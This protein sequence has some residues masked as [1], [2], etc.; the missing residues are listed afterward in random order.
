MSN[1]IPNKTD[2]LATSEIKHTSDNELVKYESL[3]NNSTVDEA[4]IRSPFAGDSKNS[5]SN[6]IKKD[7]ATTYLDAHNDIEYQ[8]N[9]MKNKE[10]SFLEMSTNNEPF[11]GFSCIAIENVPAYINKTN[12]SDDNIDN[13][14]FSNCSIQCSKS[15]LRSTDKDSKGEYSIKGIIEIRDDSN[16]NNSH[17]KRSRFL[18]SSQSH[19]TNS[20][21]E[22]LYDTCCSLNTSSNN[23]V[24]NEN[25]SVVELEK[26]NISCLMPVCSTSI[27]ENYSKEEIEELEEI[28]DKEDYIQ[29]EIISQNSSLK[30]IE[31][32]NL[33]NSNS[34]GK[35]ISF[36]T[37]RRR[38]DNTN[39]NVSIVSDDSVYSFNEKVCD[40]TV[41][42]FTHSNDLI[43]SEKSN[44]LDDVLFEAKHVNDIEQNNIDIPDTETINVEVETEI[45]ENPQIS[46]DVRNT[47]NYRESISKPIVLQPGKKWERSL[48]IYKRMTLI[49]D[50]FDT[51]MIS[52][53]PSSTRKMRQPN[54]VI[55][56]MEMQRGI[57]FCIVIFV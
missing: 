57:L 31:S 15:F 55:N 49:N 12:I 26:S 37:I 45:V 46:N 20:V 28:S 44:N 22:S 54:S 53:E 17:K 52:E 29:D 8:N 13:S 35:Y 16:D 5:S 10:A 48:S 18:T 39:N 30:S 4:P 36:V 42:S 43:N 32:E 47:I 14:I 2:K 24:E 25:E 7:R 38:N 21:R 40:E 56:T 50:N 9:N 3:K 51:S 27:L 23:T 41:I 6:E 34:D 33:H 11:L 19:N 1:V